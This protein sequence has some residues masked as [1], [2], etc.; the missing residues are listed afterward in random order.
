MTVKRRTEDAEKIAHEIKRGMYKD[1]I[2]AMKELEKIEQR[3][4]R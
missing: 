4:S 2:K 1:F 3:K